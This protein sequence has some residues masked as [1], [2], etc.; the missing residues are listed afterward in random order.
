MRHVDGGGAVVGLDLDPQRLLEFHGAMLSRAQDDQIV[1]EAWGESSSRYGEARR[2][3][4]RQEWAAYHRR[5]V[6]VFARRAAA[7]ARL[8]VA[9]SEEAE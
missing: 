3:D 5:L 2:E 1:R 6:H 9:L 4:L 7:H 8:A